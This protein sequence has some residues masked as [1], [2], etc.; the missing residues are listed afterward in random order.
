MIGFQIFSFVVLGMFFIG[1]IGVMRRKPGTVSRMAILV[2]LSIMGLILTVV[3]D[4]DISFKLAHWAGIGRG[5]DLM[6]YLAI[7]FLLFFAAAI[8]VRM[9]RMHNMI[10]ELN[11]HIALLEA[12][13]MQD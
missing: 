9:K 10:I 4:P 11:R 8:Y 12:S 1:L 3:I 13:P 2:I 6:I 5:A 7:L